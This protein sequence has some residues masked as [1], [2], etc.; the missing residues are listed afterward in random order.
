MPLPDWCQPVLSLVQ[1]GRNRFGTPGLVLL[2]AL[3][4]IVT[5]C[6]VEIVSSTPWTEK[7]RTA[8]EN[9]D[10]LSVRDRIAIGLRYGVYS[11]LACSI[12]LLVTAPW[13]SKRREGHR[14]NKEPMPNRN[15]KTTTL[16]T[17]LLAGAVLCAAWF[18]VPMLTQSFWNDEELAFRKCTWGEYRIDENGDLVFRKVP[19]SYAFFY[20]ITGNNHIAQTVLSKA[21]HD[22]A[23][24]ELEAV[25]DLPVFNEAATRIGPF[26]MGLL[27][28]VAVALW[29]WSLGFGTA[30]ILSAWVLAL[31][32]WLLRYSVEARG[33]AGMLLFVILAFWALGNALRTRSWGWWMAFAACQ[34]LYLLHFAGAAYLAA[35]MNAILF[36]SLLRHDKIGLRRWFVASVASFMVFF[37]IMAPSLVVIFNYWD[38]VAPSD[39]LR[40]SGAWLKDLWSH[41]SL[42][43]PVAKGDPDLAWGIGLENLIGDHPVAVTLLWVVILPVLMIAEVILAS[44]RM[45]YLAIFFGSLIGAAALAIVYT[46]WKGGALHEWYLLYLVPAVSIALALVGEPDMFLKNVRRPWIK[47][48]PTALCVAIIALT[49]ILTAPQREAVQLHDRHP[50]RQAVQ[51]VR[52]E[53]PALSPRQKNL[54]SISVGAGSDKLKT[55]DPRVQQCRSVAELEDILAEAGDRPVA[56]YCC[57]PRN[58]RLFNPDLWAA[59]AESGRFEPG[60]LLKGV[61]EFWSF[62]IFTLRTHPD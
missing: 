37:Q 22:E 15:W 16:F 19:W 10:K 11:T 43:V 7:V 54:V 33:Y 1:R 12:L 42:G 32:P 62:Q 36:W 48:L 35:V 3:V 50:M 40:I 17:V 2:L 45:R 39:G 47:F 23:T 56:V 24:E 21:V 44:L 5:V 60:R 8:I 20:N 14:W 28:L 27:T 55:Y 51:F 9:G 57:G 38:Q 41:L 58:L 4:S 26:V 59:I 53:S 61:E 34:C 13:W 52:G 31:H 6:L 29:L 25:G 46:F 49:A 18:R 30:G